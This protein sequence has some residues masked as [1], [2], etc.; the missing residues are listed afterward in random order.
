MET[1][2]AFMMEGKILFSTYGSKKPWRGKKHKAC[3]KVHNSHEPRCRETSLKPP[4]PEC[5]L[6]HC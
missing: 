2:G 4:D 1:T 3:S 6:P 5:C